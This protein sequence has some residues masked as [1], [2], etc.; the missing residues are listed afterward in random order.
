[1]SDT[2]TRY[3]EKDGLVKLFHGRTKVHEFEPT[4]SM[5]D[6]LSLADEHLT[7]A[8]EFDRSP[9]TLDTFLEQVELLDD[10]DAEAEDKEEYSGNV[11]PKKYKDRYGKKQN[12][13]D[14]IAEAITTGV[15]TL[16]DTTK[17]N[18]TAGKPTKIVNPDSLVKVQEANGID[19]QK[20]AHLNPGMQV[21][22]TSNVIRGMF[23][24][25]EPIEA[26][27]LKLDLIKETES[28]AKAGPLTF[29]DVD[30][31]LERLGFSTITKHHDAVAKLI[32]ELDG[33]KPDE[34]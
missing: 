9:A 7:E 28:L 8:A 12:C 14:P 31:L 20:W 32:F 6:V 17:K 16:I 18:G 3:T 21:M 10:F 11:V 4:A 25:G 26:F 29:G 27:K 19:G 30:E 24:R 23:W 13:G 5:G 1:M 15:V 22:N 2:F 34:A 33:E